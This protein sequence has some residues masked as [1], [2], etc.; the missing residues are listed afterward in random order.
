MDFEDFVVEFR[1]SFTSGLGGFE[2]SRFVKEIFLSIVLIKD[3]EDTIE[4]IGKIK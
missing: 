3:Y 4:E 1:Y 2:Y